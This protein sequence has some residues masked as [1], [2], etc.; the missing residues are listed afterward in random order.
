MGALP[1]IADSGTPLPWFCSVAERR[2]AFRANRVGRSPSRRAVS[3]ITPIGRRLLTLPRLR[4]A[5]KDGRE[6]A[7]VDWLANFV[8]IKVFR[9][10]QNAITLGRVM[11]HVPP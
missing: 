5:S 1:G 8:L 9:A 3:A 10:W 2:D 11:V 6:P 7:M 4:L